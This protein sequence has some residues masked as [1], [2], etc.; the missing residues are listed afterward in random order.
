MKTKASSKEGKL[1]PFCCAGCGSNY[2]APRVKNF[3]QWEAAR[4]CDECSDPCADGCPRGC[5]HDKAMGG[6][7]SNG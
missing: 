2:E 7:Q 3:N 1:Y 4:D 6:K 5:A